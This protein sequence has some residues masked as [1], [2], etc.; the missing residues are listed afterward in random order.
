[1]IAERL[2]PTLFLVTYAA[3][4]SL[5]LTMPLALLAAV[6]QNRPS[7]QPCASARR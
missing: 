7:D 4:L 5:L 1:M 6:R 2:P 3:V